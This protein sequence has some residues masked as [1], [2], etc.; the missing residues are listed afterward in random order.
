MREVTPLCVS[1][2]TFTYARCIIMQKSEIRIISWILVWNLANNIEVEETNR[3]VE[4]Y[5]KENESLIK[6]NAMKNV[7]Y[8]E[9]FHGLLQQRSRFANKLVRTARVVCC[10]VA[11][12]RW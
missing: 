10:R 12:K 6:K 9:S 11:M 1:F 2:E 4:Q 5:K 7:R 8:L 3:R